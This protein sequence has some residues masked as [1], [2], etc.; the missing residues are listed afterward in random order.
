V[1]RAAEGTG[2]AS[3]WHAQA[4]GRNFRTLF[5]IRAAVPYKNPDF[6]ENLERLVDNFPFPKR[7]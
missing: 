7:F 3:S 1:R 2:S 4:Q 6:S 5:R